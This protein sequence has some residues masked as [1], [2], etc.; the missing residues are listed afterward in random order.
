[1]ALP[2]VITINETAYANSG[3]SKL[4][5]ELGGSEINSRAATELATNADSWVG[6]SREVL[7]DRLEDFEGLG[8]NGPMSYRGTCECFQLVEGAKL[9]AALQKLGA[10]RVVVSHE[11]YPDYQ[12]ISRMAGLAIVANTGMGSGDEGAR[13]SAVS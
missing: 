10:D 5:T 12:I 7:A 8:P 9:K 2:V 4:V 1:M 6:M 3:L 11:A 13:L